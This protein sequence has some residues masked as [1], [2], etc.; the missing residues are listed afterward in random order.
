MKFC[1]E[2]L[3]TLDYHTVKAEIFVSLG[4]ESVPGRDR[5]TDTKTDRITAANTRY[6]LIILI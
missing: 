3:K 1:D 5:Q 6:H 2:I 4:F